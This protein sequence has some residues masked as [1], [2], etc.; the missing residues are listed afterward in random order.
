MTPLT[1]R[2]GRRTRRFR[3]P[4]TH[5]V[6]QNRAVHEKLQSRLDFGVELSLVFVPLDE[7]DGRVRL[8]VTPYDT[9]QAGRQILYRGRVGHVRRV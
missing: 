6:N 3:F 8:D 7:L 5:H 1:V 9:L 4:N 2:I